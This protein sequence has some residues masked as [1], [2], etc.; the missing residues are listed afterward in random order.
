MVAHAAPAPLPS[1]TRRQRQQ[2]RVL[3]ALLSGELNGRW[4][5]RTARGFAWVLTVYTCFPFLFVGT[6]SAPLAAVAIRENLLAL[7]WLAGFAALTVAAPRSELYSRQL[8]TLR[9]LDT[10]LLTRVEWASACSVPFRVLLPAGLVVSTLALITSASLRAAGAALLTW[11]GALI[12]LVLAAG[13]FGMLASWAQRLSPTRGR[14]LYLLLIF[15]PLLLARA[16]ELHSVPGLLSQLLG[17]CLKLG[18]A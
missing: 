4:L 2:E 18:G 7:S 5:A 6:R 12:Y 1:A 13:I 16:L 3:Y 10:A 11:V 15:L 8:V 14:S 17:W 9:G